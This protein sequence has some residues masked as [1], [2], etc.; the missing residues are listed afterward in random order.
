MKEL[1]STA[2]SPLFADSRA[3]NDF[4]RVLAARLSR[5]SLLKGSLA[6]AA[7][8][9]LGTSL[10]L[11]ASGDVQA[12]TRTL[13]L[14]FKAIPKSVDDKIAIANGYQWQVLLA[15][16]DPLASDVP[17]YANDGSDEAGSFTRRVG[18]HHDGMHFFG[19]THAARWD[20]QRSERG[21][22]CINHEAV[23]A[24]FLHAQGDTVAD[25][26][27]ISEDEV[28]KEMLAHGVSIV[29][30]RRHQ[31]SYVMHQD[32]LLNRRITPDS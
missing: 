12:A 24:A 23:T 13:K 32:S 28:M 21:L 7:T 10:G 20:A 6:T 17:P 18:D 2:D 19:M 25:D 31:G 27:R 26:K 5:R 29:E 22:L 14:N 1:S 4:E 15:T 30:V 8:A 3:S 11:S 16:G 9:Y